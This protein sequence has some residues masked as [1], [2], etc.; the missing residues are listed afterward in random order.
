MK[1]N[2]LF[3]GLLAVIILTACSESFFL[4]NSNGAVVTQEVYDA[5]AKSLDAHLLGLYELMTASMISDRHDVYGQKSNDIYT[6][7]LCSDAAIKKPYLSN[8]GQAELMQFHYST[9]GFNQYQCWNFYYKIIKNTNI[10][11]RNVRTLIANNAIDET[12]SRHYLGQAMA[13]RAYAYFNLA[14]LYGATPKSPKD[15]KNLEP[16]EQKCLPFYDETVSDTLPV[17]LSSLGEVYEKIQI[18]LENAVE[19]LKDYVRPTKTNIDVDVARVLLASAM[20]QRGVY[21]DDNSYFIAA[22]DAAIEVINGNNF[23]ILDST[24]LTTTGFTDIGSKSWM[25]GQ[26]VSAETTGALRSFWGRVDIFTY[27]YAFG[28]YHVQIDQYLFDDIKT[29]HPND[30]RLK[31][32][33]VSQT[34]WNTSDQD[35]YKYAPIWKF[36]HSAR[37]F[38]NPD[39]AWLSDILYMRVE[40]AYLIAAEAAKRAGDDANASYYLKELVSQRDPVIAAGITAGSTDLLDLI[41]YN[42]RVEMWLEGRGLRTFKRFGESNK[43]RGTNHFRDSTDPVNPMSPQY[44]FE[45]PNSEKVLNPYITD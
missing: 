4:R 25:W 20:L 29:N 42:W 19:Y 30:K 44:T 38:N 24:N 41:K 21:D 13:M 36:Y 1:F 16:L 45:L 23:A 32:W 31:W 2:K 18:D 34:N 27:S 33:D 37:D 28:G 3:F 14:V 17:G 12:L 26:D 40:E 11:I 6:D 10:V 22:R 15:K 9:S 5:N 8:D 43:G 35:L 39:K 7:I